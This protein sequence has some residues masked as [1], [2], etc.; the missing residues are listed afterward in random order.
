MA[1]AASV[2]IVACERAAAALKRWVRYLSPPARQAAPNTSRMLPIME[3]VSEAFTT[4]KS[5]CLSALMAIISSAALPKVAFSSPPIPSPVR[6]ARCSVAWPSQPARGST[7]RQAAK[8]MAVCD[9]GR[10]CSSQTARG[11][12]TSNQFMEGFNRFDIQTGFQFS[13]PAALAARLAG[14]FRLG[15]DLRGASGT[16]QRPRRKLRW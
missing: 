16:D 6:S 14:A 8:K 5:P 10:A 9:A 7:A 13:C 15:A 12:N 11:I 3:P 2:S 1:M 4:A